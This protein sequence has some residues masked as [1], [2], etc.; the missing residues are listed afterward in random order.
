MKKKMVL[1]L[2]WLRPAGIALLYFLAEWLGKDPAGK[3]H[4][5]GPGLALIL[6]GSVGLESL[7][8]GET[9]SEKIGYASDRAYQVQSGLNHLALA[10]AALLVLIFNWGKFADAAITTVL[11]LVFTFSALNHLFTAIKN[12]N[13][14]P[15][16]LL[17]PIM[18][19]LL[20]AILLPVMLK[21]LG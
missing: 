21:A 2:E 17:R 4:I 6:S 16:N 12:R 8:F 18:T 13:F 1:W 7:F 3:L 20:I 9:A 10:A 14:K 11:L 19:A 5:L 15:V